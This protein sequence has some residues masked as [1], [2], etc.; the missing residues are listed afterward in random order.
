MADLLPYISRN[1][2]GVT[3]DLWKKGHSVWLSL[4]V[5]FLDRDDSYILKQLESH[6]GVYPWCQSVLRQQLDQGNVDPQVLHLIFLVHVR[7]FNVVSTTSSSSPLSLV[8]LDTFAL[9]FARTNPVV[10]RK[11]FSQL[12]DAQMNLRAQ[13]TA[14]LEQVMDT[15]ASL[16]EATT[17]TADKLSFLQRMNVVARLLET[18]VLC[19]CLDISI[20]R[21]FP[22]LLSCYEKLLVINN[23]GDDDTVEIGYWT[24][25]VKQSLINVL[26]TLVEI[27]YIS[28]LGYVTKDQSGNMDK[29][30]D[31]QTN[32]AQ[33]IVESLCE[34]I[35]QWVE[36]SGVESSKTV[37]VDAPLIMD[38]QVEWQMAKR[39][40][41]INKDLFYGEN[42]QLS[43]ISLVLDTQIQDLATGI[44]QS[45]GARIKEQQDDY[46]VKNI[47]TIDSTLS[48][49]SADP[50]HRA[51]LIS[52]VRDIFSDL[53]EG[54][55]EACLEANNNDAEMV[56]MQLL[57]NNLP[58][59]V[60]SLDRSMGSNHSSTSTVTTATTNDTMTENTSILDSRKN[61]FDKDEFD[62]FSGGI[63]QRNKVYLGKKNKGTAETLLDSKKHTQDEKANMLRRIY[64]MYEDEI[65]DS[66]DAVNEM[67]GP[68]DL[69]AVEEGGQSAVDVVQ[70]KKNQHVDSVMMYEMYESELIQL[71]AEQPES[72]RQSSAGRRSHK[73][74]EL[75]EKTGMS[76][77]Q[78]KGWAR[79]L[80]DNPRRKQQVLDKHMLFDGTQNEIDDKVKA[81][82]QQQQK[83]SSTKPP[84]PSEAKQKAYKDKNKARIGNHNR[85]RNHDKKLNRLA[86]PTNT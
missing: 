53:G 46:G 40:K 84:P 14:E 2:P 62:V 10:V 34:Q 22:I 28:A 54:F 51:S 8:A 69:A 67:S 32:D 80:D 20:P 23:D 45:W 17:A 30:C 16:D 83:E 25:L 36:Q 71:Y 57:E 29:I 43:F 35:L 50:I 77:E 48:I 82:Q 68:V 3:E 26:N 66:Y 49:P 60:A 81:K 13:Y 37:Y 4:L 59:S 1:T 41:R 72:F 56:I 31:I 38:W 55:I 64:D 70:A 7:L 79:H 5:D 39:V 61:I 6:Q 12:F 73:W 15:L 76:D 42:E 44:Q 11:L 24:Y 9:V 19:L 74:K 47:T 33:V 78:L 18:K 86:G 58:P 65:D 52:Q 63:V 75:R 27:N 85:K 21:L